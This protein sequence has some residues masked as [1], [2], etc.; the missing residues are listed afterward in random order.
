MVIHELHDDQ[1]TPGFVLLRQGLEQLPEQNLAI[2]YHPHFAKDT[3]NLFYLLN[4]G[5]YSLGSGCY[6]VL[7]KEGQYIGSAGWN[8][9][10]DS[11]VLCLT[12]AYFVKEHRHQ[13]YMAE[14]LLPKIF[15]QTKMFNTFWI[16]CNDYNKNIY[17]GLSRMQSGRSVGLYNSWPNIYKKFVPVGTRLVNNT[18]QYVAEYKR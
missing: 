14:Y 8:V 2:N 7:E 15:E 4:T 3:A 10:S 17:D 5:R 18:P 11:I 1:E 13:Y 6:F 12:R 16:T 9:Y